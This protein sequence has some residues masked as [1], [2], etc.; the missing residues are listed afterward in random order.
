MEYLQHKGV[1]TLYAQSLYRCAP[2]RQ[3]EVSSRL[4]DSGRAQHRQP[5]TTA[6]PCTA[7]GGAGSGIIKA[8]A[9]AHCG[10]A[11]RGVNRALKEWRLGQYHVVCGNR[12]HED[13]D[14]GVSAA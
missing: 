6:G 4:V 3:H 12:L 11:T 7:Y 9:A 1:R 13:Q 2:G 8:G 14:H 5:G 10:Q